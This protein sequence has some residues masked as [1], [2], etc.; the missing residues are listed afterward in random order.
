MAV[1]SSPERRSTTNTPTT[2]R[3][4]YRN[5]YTTQRGQDDDDESTQRP[6]ETTKRPSET[7]IQR[8]FIESGPSSSSNKVAQHNP[9]SS[10]SSPPKK[11][12]SLKGGDLIALIVCEE[13]EQAIKALDDNPK[14]ARMPQP[15]TLDGLDSQGLPL[16]LAACSRPPVRVLSYERNFSL[17]N[18]R[19][20]SIKY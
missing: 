17:E 4:S 20:K 7:T 1:S 3:D 9:S 15:I 11:T 12:S 5:S 8:A 16:H 10:S 18:V 6:S 2:N 13:W 19:L 14:V